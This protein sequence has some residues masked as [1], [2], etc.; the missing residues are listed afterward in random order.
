MFTAGSINYA[1][2][3]THYPEMQIYSQQTK[4]KAVP[5]HATKVLGGRGGIAPTHSRWG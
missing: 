1:N 4:A 5:L 2:T 3:F